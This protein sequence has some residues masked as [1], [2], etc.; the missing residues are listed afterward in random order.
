[1]PFTNLN[2][3]R[4]KFYSK[5]TEHYADAHP[6]GPDG[7]YKVCVELQMNYQFPAKTKEEEA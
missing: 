7:L 1:M 3:V 5:P 6:E 4:A 2:D